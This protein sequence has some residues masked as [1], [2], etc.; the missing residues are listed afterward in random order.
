M[1]QPTWQRLRRQPRQRL[2]RATIGLVAIAATIAAPLARGDEFARRRAMR[3]TPAVE[4]FEKWKDSVVTVSGPIVRSKKPLPDEFFLL[5]GDRSEENSVGTGFVIHEAGYLVTNAHAAETVISHRVALADGKTYPAELI[6]CLHDEDLALLKIDADRPLRGV[7]LAHSDDLMIGET[8]I[9]IANPHGLLYTCSA[10]VL[11]AVGRTATVADIPGL[12]LRDLIQTDAGINPGSS[13]GP[14]FNVL[15]EVIGLTATM[16]R[17]SENIAFAVPVASLRKVLPSMLDVE[18]R[19]RFQTGIDPSLD[20]PCRVTAVAAESP[21]AQAGVQPGDQITRLAGQAIDTS[22]DYH[23][24]LV[25]RNPGESVAMDLIRDG[26]PL[27]VSLDLTSRPKPDTA[28]LLRQKLGLTAAPL[29]DE[30]VKAMSLRVPRGVVIASIDPQ[31]YQQVQHKPAPGDVLAS[32]NRIRPR[33]MDHLGLLMDQVRPGQRVSMVILRAANG[34]ATRMDLN[35]T[36]P[37]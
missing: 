28:A 9:V 2:Q 36:W 11:S 14:W 8:V 18:R 22:A 33:D 5:P 7:R 10:G 20:G 34:V 30:R 6:A 13:G 1:Q 35:M 29:D 25:G 26:Q 23:L 3:R 21:A 27:Q 24:A 31:W 32:F 12:T 16:R 17:D 15:G 19:Y 37:Q 4:V